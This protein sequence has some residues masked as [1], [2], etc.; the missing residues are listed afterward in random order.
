M[1]RRNISKVI[2]ASAVGSMLLPRESHA[3]SCTL[4][5]Y[6]QT[7]AESA[8]GITPTNPSFPPGNVLRYGADATGALD[9]Q[10][11][12]AA[13][14]TVSD[15][16][17]V[18]IGDYKFS[19]E[20]VVNKNNITIAG[21]NR[22]RT[23]SG[24]RNGGACITLAAS[25]GSGA[26]ALRWSSSHGLAESVYISGLCIRLKN[27]GLAQ[28]GMRFHE[29]RQSKIKECWIEGPAVSG[30]DTIG[31]LLDGGGTFTGDLDIESNFISNHAIGI[32]VRGI[33]TT[34]RI[35]E[36]DMVGT[37]AAQ[38]NTRAIK[39]AN[40]SNS[41]L[42]QGNTIDNWGIGIYTEGSNIRQI[43]NYFDFNATPWQWVRG[44]GNPD[45][46]NTS[47]ADARLSGGSPIFPV[48]NVDRCIH[49]GTANAIFDGAIVQA[50][51]GFKSDVSAW[52]NTPLTLGVYRLWIDA[53]GKL[54]IK[55]SA[56]TSDTDGQVV[57]TQT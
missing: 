9:S 46:F 35:R 28:R 41:T 20:L 43:G 49:I 5:C 45:I 22:G 24:A 21:E 13:A 38:P 55:S 36:N 1:D 51:A 30:D 54:R 52:N 2:L 15:Y 40:T 47:V 7:A 11:A 25:A 27:A 17:Y 8:A 3:Q 23:L 48:N 16:V 18:P 10:P 34:V 6:P 4:P 57:G 29:L 37:A 53:S 56:P 19:A 12:F 33:C 50:G 44:A 32:D 26:A 31:I 39:I 14:C 42:I